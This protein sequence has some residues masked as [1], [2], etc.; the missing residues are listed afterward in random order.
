M[1]EH[2]IKMQELIAKARELSRKKVTRTTRR[3]LKEGYKFYLLLPGRS[4][5]RV[6]FRDTLSAEH[7]KKTHYGYSAADTVYELVLPPKMPWE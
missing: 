6:Y 3:K 2:S 4:G 5:Y 7:W 1:A